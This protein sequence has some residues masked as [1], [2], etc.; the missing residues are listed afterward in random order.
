MDGTLYVLDER[1][2]L[3]CAECVAQ[4][5]GVKRSNDGNSWTFLLTHALCCYQHWMEG[6]HNLFCILDVS[7]SQGR[8]VSGILSDL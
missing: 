1:G 3:N 2:I 5:L 7:I 4:K 8:D 6:F